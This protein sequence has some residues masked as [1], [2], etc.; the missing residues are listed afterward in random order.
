MSMSNINQHKNI[1]NT[2]D[3]NIINYLERILQQQEDIFNRK[4]ET[5]QKQHNKM[6]KIIIQQQQQIKTLS[7]IQGQQRQDLVK[8]RLV[9]M[10]IHLIL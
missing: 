10:K 2:E 6:E 4:L 9:L 5:I 1:I 7:D 3:T 8:T